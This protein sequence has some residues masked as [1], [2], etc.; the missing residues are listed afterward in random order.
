M[1]NISAKYIAYLSNELNYSEHTCISYKNDIHI[2][3]NYINEEGIDYADVDY[4]AIRY[5]IVSLSKQQYSRNSIR[6]NLSAVSSFYNY[7]IKNKICLQNPVSMVDTIKKEQH[8]PEFLYVEEVRQ[9]VQDC[10]NRKYSE[11]DKLIIMILFFNGLRVSELVDIKLKDVN[12]NKIKINGKGNKDR[13]IVLSKT[14]IEQI[15]KYINTD[16]ISLVKGENPYLFI[17]NK[18][19][20]LTSRG[21]RYI[22]TDITKKGEL[23]KNVYPHMLRHSFATYFLSNGSDLRTVQTFLGHENISTTQVYT[24]LSQEELEKSYDNF[25]PRSKRSK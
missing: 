1:L 14:V 7:L 10:K 19:T 24:H 11:R 4:F 5:Y 18:G 22:I 16:R 6:R 2:F 23:E 3:A 13:Y 15:N 9:L 17:N 12:S 20:N 25:H 21:I 8:L